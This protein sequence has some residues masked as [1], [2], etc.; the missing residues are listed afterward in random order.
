MLYCCGA[1]AKWA[2]RDDLFAETIGWIH[3]QW[4]VLGKPT[5]WLACPSC[6][7]MFNEYLPEIKTVSLYEALP[8]ASRKDA[9]F[10]QSVN[11]SIGVCDPCAARHD[12]AVQ[13]AVRRLLSDREFSIEEIPFHG[14]TAQCCGFGGLMAAANP[15]L[16]DK[17]ISGRIHRSATD[18]VTYCA[19]CRDRLV[20]GGK[21]I[22]H[23]LQILFP[24]ADP[25]EKPAPGWS[26]RHENRGRLKE[27]LLAELWH[28]ATPG[29]GEAEAIPLILSP[30]VRALMETRRI[31]VTDI[32]K[33]IAH[34]ESGGRFLKNPTTGRMLAYFR[35][36]NVTFWVEYGREAEGVVVH[37]LYCHRMEILE[38]AP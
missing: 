3:D 23:V 11:R 35:P 10:P 26:E 21:R 7:A 28:K 36:V 2:C 8:G 30:E 15:E 34:T 33:V 13:K 1:P 4:T 17:V 38:A 16:G 24:D 18:W 27:R 25:F 37:N 6:Q 29:K 31:L 14:K 5:V 12:T 20:K 9:A 22:A 19:M 32:Q